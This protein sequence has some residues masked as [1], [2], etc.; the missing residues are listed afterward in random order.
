MYSPALSVCKVLV[1][2]VLSSV[3]RTV[4]SGTI[5]PFLSVSVPV[6]VARSTCAKPVRLNADVRT[7]TARQ[8]TRGMRFLEMDDPASRRIMMISSSLL[9]GEG[10]SHAVCATCE[11]QFLPDPARHFRKRV[12]GTAAIPL[13][14]EPL[15]LRFRLLLSPGITAYQY[16]VYLRYL[17]TN[18]LMVPQSCH[19]D[20]SV[21]QW[22]DLRFLFR[23]S[24][25]LFSVD[26][27]KSDYLTI[28]RRRDDSCSVIYTA[29][30]R[31]CLGQRMEPRQLPIGLGATFAEGKESVRRDRYGF[32]IYI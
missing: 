9:A 10:N 7:S 30:L 16:P 22:R 4:A 27:P 18:W 15:V 23:F 1:S 13:C 17:H 6:M 11:R 12:N 3:T 25:G 29:M 20:R 26:L 32:W 24:L 21:A 19:P 5:D 28:T 2:F 14:Q 8:C 31:V